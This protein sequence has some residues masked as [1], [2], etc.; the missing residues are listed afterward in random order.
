M[1]EVRK[2]PQFLHDGIVLD[3]LCSLIIRM[4]SFPRDSKGSGLN[5]ELHNKIDFISS[6]VFS[7]LADN[8]NN[9]HGVLLNTLSSI[10]MIRNNGAIEGVWKEGGES[11]IKKIVEDVIHSGSYRLDMVS[12]IYH[13]ICVHEA[14]RGFSEGTL[15]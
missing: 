2:D 8:E 14:S 6:E 3:N 15:E 11:T 13:A 10:I 1:E 4:I 9:R 12:H 7:I 5:K